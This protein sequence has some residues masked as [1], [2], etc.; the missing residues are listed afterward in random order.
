MALYFSSILTKE[1]V[2]LSSILWGN[3][4]MIVLT[5]YSETK[6]DISR[7]HSHSFGMNLQ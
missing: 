1:P 5:S 7:H 6:S 4:Q 3:P 2:V